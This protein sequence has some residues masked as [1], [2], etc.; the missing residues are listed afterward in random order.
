LAAETETIFY[1]KKSQEAMI[2]FEGLN[3]ISFLPFANFELKQDLNSMG[4]FLQK[5]IKFVSCPSYKLIFELM[6]QQFLK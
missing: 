6:I 3:R 5:F 2:L 4:Q 1:L